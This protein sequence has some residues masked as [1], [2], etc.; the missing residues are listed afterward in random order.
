MFFD[1][2]GFLLPFLFFLRR[3]RRLQYCYNA[4][5]SACG[6]SGQWQRSKELL[7]AMREK[8][9]RPDLISYN[10]AIDACGKG[11]RWVGRQGEREGGK[12]EGAVCVCVCFPRQ[13]SAVLAAWSDFLSRFVFCF[14]LVPMHFWTTYRYIHTVRA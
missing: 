13:R 9:V 7:V 10:S 5:I 2:H 1:G 12:G 8:G 14:V 11:G 4:A 6:K 3:F